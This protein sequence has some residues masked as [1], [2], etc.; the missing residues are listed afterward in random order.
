[1]MSFSKSGSPTINATTGDKVLPLRFWY[2]NDVLSKL[3]LYFASQFED[4]LDPEKLIGNWHLIIGR[5]LQAECQCSITPTKALA[6]IGPQT[7][8]LDSGQDGYSHSLL[9]GCQGAEV[10][11]PTLY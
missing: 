8:V 9:D 7:H 1:M 6:A 11:R 3:A 4:V 2:S 5:A 10:L